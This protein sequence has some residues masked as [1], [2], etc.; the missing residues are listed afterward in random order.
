MKFI[1]TINSEDVSDA[2][3]ATYAVRTAARAILRDREGNI[4]TLN[5][6]KKHYHKLP[7]GGIEAGESAFDALR[8]ECKEELGCE[9]EIGEEVGE[10]VE[11]RKKYRLKQTSFCYLAWVVGEK[12][13]PEFAKEENEEGFKI[14]RVSIGEMT[15]FL[16]SDGTEDYEGKFYVVPRDEAFLD[17]ARRLNFH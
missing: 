14:Q 10:I 4:G 1:A 9:I 12:G 5:V 17:A 16:A 2:E 6:S 11:Y 15:A 8:R 7:G 13:Q 3:A